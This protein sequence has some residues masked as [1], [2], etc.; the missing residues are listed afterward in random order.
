MF[1]I[2]DQDGGGEISKEELGELMKTLNIPF[3]PEEL[4]AIVAEV[5][6]DGS[7]H[8]ELSEFVAVMSKK[9]DIPYTSR[10]VKAAFKVFQGDAP[11][12]M[13]KVDDLAHILS[14]FNASLS[15]A[16]AKELIA[17]MEPDEKTGLVAYSTYVDMMMGE[18]GKKQK[19]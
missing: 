4:E 12:G 14:T 2:L 13:V 17:Q 5:D 10:E 19:K 6:E 3:K 16:E 11:A 8:I 15:E 9:V 7:G 18:P 1:N